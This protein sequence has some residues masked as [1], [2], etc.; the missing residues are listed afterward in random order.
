MYNRVWM[1]L[2]STYKHIEQAAK[3][4]DDHERYTN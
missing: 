4:M 1:P 2:A 3:L